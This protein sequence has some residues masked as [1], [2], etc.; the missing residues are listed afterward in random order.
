MSDATDRHRLLHELT[1]SQSLA[2]DALDSGCT[3]AQAAEAA[4]V[5]RTTV[6]RWTSK[7]P[8]F[9]AELNQ[10]KADRADRN[11]ERLQELT[12]TALDTVEGSMAEGDAGA[13][14]QWL[15]LRG[16]QSMETDFNGPVT[17]DGVIENYRS[18]MRTENEEELYRMIGHRSRDEA[19][20]DL[21]RTFDEVDDDDRPPEPV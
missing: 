16:L 20:D 8:A 13:A 4:S 11:A 9:K 10:R 14:L 17:A 1:P 15:K 5:D 6:S 12:E 3:H 18:K 2:L 7:H 19:V 21:L